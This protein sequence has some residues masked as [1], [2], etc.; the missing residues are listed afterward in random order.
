MQGRGFKAP[1]IPQVGGAGAG[2]AGVGGAGAGGEGVGQVEVEWEGVWAAG[3]G[4][5][6]GAGAM[7]GGFPQPCAASPVPAS[8]IGRR[9]GTMERRAGAGQRLDPPAAFGAPAPAGNA[10]LGPGPLWAQG[11][12]RWSDPCPLGRSPGA[13]APL[14]LP[15]PHGSA[16]GR[17]PV[18]L[19]ATRAELGA[20]GVGGGGVPGLQGRGDGPARRPDQVTAPRPLP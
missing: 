18:R 14:A 6:R 11:R 20:P 5:V 10:W 4:G 13:D 15:A 8:P 12:G 1:S 9:R 16:P 7:R 3:A 17:R 2:G 19:E